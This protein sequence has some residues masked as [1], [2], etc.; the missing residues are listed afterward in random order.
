MRMRDPGAELD[1]ATEVVLVGDV[2]QVPQ[3]LGLGGVLLRPLPVA[4]PVRIEA[5]HV[6]DAGDVDAGAG[7][8]VPVPGAADVVA[9]LEDAHRM[10]REPKTVR[11]VQTGEA[12]AHNHN[13]RVGVFISHATNHDAAGAFCLVVEF[14][15]RWAAGIGR[16]R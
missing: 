12:G 9:G 16:A 13:I 14:A 7:V 10:T 8:A 3:D 5:E 2:V 4:R 1:V 11:G 15:N 6:V